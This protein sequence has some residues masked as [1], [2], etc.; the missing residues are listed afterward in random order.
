MQN[1]TFQI[2]KIIILSSVE[3]VAKKSPKGVFLFFWGEKWGKTKSLSKFNYI[4]Q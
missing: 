2:I 4:R 1:I 3:K